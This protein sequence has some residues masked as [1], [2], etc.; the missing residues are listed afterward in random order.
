[1]IISKIDML[2]KEE[3]QNLLDNSNSYSDVF[4]KLNLKIG[5]QPYRKIKSRI[6]NDNLDI[7]KFTKN[8]SNMYKKHF[9]KISTKLTDDEIFVIDSTHLNNALIKKRL[10][11]YKDYKCEI[12]GL[13]NWNNKPISLQLHHI[14][15]INNDNRLEN[16]L[17]LC[18]NCHS[19][20][21]NYAGANIKTKAVKI[22]DNIVCKICGKPIDKY[23]KHQMCVKCAGELRRKVVRPSKDELLFLI[24][25]KP[26]YKI[27]IDY[28]VSGNAI[29][30]W[31]KD[32]GISY[33]K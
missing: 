15:G 1:M 16:L 10:L 28:G 24:K 3:L 12:C 7:S 11:K 21:D 30:K 22:K 5:S 13:I 9:S 2:S 27:G 33:K 18:P 17:L 6:K 32:Y 20:T 8:R 23:G 29:K 14:N 4:R 19:Q 26:M 31:C 25:N